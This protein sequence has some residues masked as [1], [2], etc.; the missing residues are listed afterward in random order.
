MS[1][2]SDTAQAGQDSAVHSTLHPALHPSITSVPVTPGVHL[3]GRSAYL[4]P[5]QPFQDKSIP[6]RSDGGTPDSRES[7]NSY[8]VPDHGGSGSGTGKEMPR[9]L[10]MAEKA[11][12]ADTD[13]RAAYPKL[14]L[15]GRIISATFCVPYN[16]EFTPSHDWVSL[17]I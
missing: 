12:L 7:A 4:E 14:S 8:F 17:L 3:S 9:Q 15:S 1:T 2:P 11:R 5:E 16:I 13:P 6:F 10:S